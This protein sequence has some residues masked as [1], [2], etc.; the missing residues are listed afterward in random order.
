MSKKRNGQFLCGMCKAHFNKLDGA[1]HHVSDKHAGNRVVIYKSCEIID[2]IE[3]D[4]DSFADRA[5]AASIAR[6]MGERTDD[7][8]LIP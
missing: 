1:R 3:D 7:G 4:D 5:I 8:W 6:A 2:P